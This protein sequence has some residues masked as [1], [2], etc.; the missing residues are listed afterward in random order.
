MEP[1]LAALRD[2]AAD[3][4]MPRGASVLLAVSGGADS[5]A[6]LYGV[7]ETSPDQGWRVVVGHVHHGWRGREADRDLAFVLD[8]SRR[9]KLTFAFL[10]RDARGEARAL[11]L[12][13]EAGARYVRY[14]ALREMATEAG[15]EIIATAH[16][17]DDRVE[18]HLL[19]RERGAGL[20][21]LAG[22]RRRRSDGVVRPLL[23]VSRREILEFLTG[24]GVGHRRDASNGDLRL[25]RNRIRREVAALLA[26]SADETLREI[27]AEI[28]RYS[29]RRDAV[30]SEFARNVEPRIFRGPGTV[31][32]DAPYLQAC[33]HD[34]Q[35]LAIERAALPFARPGRAP[36]TGREREQILV[37]LRGGR[38]FRFEAGRRI[39]FDRRGAVLRV[40][41]APARASGAG[42]P[43]Q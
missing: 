15:C 27:E 4:L 28:E 26:G 8:H 1:V 18:T 9:L 2:A 11:K 20:A 36:L 17:R 42:I 43:G 23:E 31:V 37:Q 32:A 35:R 10:R 25:A 41:A 19:A 33:G 14:A 34:L 6:L 22:L 30:E 3:E 16:Q 29:S 38:D 7:A 12:S 5:M 39:R 24:R 40:Q 13:P 21:G